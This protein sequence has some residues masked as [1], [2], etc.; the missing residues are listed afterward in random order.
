[1]H[2][3]IAE[4]LMIPQPIVNL[5]NRSPLKLSACRGQNFGNPQKNP[6]YYNGKVLS[7]VYLKI[8]LPKKQCEKKA[9]RYPIQILRF[10]HKTSYVFRQE[11]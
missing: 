1:M 11:N 2:T 6:V 5:A 8:S 10:S 4:E 3:I 7:E 9:G